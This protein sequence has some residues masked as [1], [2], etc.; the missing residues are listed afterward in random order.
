M[1]RV[2][3]ITVGAIAVLIGA[4][5]LF[6]HFDP[7]CGEDLMSE[8]TSPDGRYVAAWMIR[9]CGATTSYVNHVNLRL[10]SSPFHSDFF[11]GTISD[12]EVLTLAKYTSRVH[13]CWI[14]ARRFNIEFP[15]SDPGL[16]NLSSWREVEITYGNACP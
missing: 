13:Y 9:N 1:P 3:L 4:G 5:A 11:N 2:L 10:A 8:Q 7:L 12:G 14:G 6:L 16:K 15:D